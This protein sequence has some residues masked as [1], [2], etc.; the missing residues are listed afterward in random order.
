MK[1]PDYE[2]HL[3]EAEIDV[4]S[5][6]G[7]CNIT[8]HACGGAGAKK[9]NPGYDKALVGILNA[10]KRAKRRVAK[11]YVSSGPAMELEYEKD[12]LLPSL[13]PDNT[14]PNHMPPAVLAS[15]LKSEMAG[16]ARAPNATGGGN[17]QKRITISVKG[18]VSFDFIE[19]ESLE[20][21]IN[22]NEDGRKRIARQIAVRRGQ[23]KFRKELIAYFGECVITGCK[24]I[25]ALEAAHIIP[26]NG[27]ETNAIY[28]G[29]L[30]RSD[31]HTLFDLS[32]VKINP[33]SMAVEWAP[34]IKSG[35]YNEMT[36]PIAF[37]TDK[38]LAPRI[39]SLEHKYSERPSEEVISGR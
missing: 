24:D 7:G 30:L 32:L 31:I 38:Y 3:I 26:Y 10:I 9:T 20:N 25:A 28:N 39:I 34:T 21:V 17:R 36:G 22:P 18:T 33:S 29:L 15:R 5:I 37:K 16:I 2:G 27:D 6:A 8:L 11:A 19:A 1:I 14:I 35:T 12:R 23:P 4:E 13:P